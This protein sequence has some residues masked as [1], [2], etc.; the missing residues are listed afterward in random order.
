MELKEMIIKYEEL[1]A[2]KDELSDE[3]KANNAAIDEIKQQIADQM[4][5]D[6]MPTIGVGDYTYSLQMGIKYG[7]KSEAALAQ[8]GLNKMDVLR[9]NGY[10]FLITERV[11]PRT[12]N[13]TMREAAESEEGIPE[14]IEEI[15]SQY[16]YQDIG[17]RKSS[18]KALKKK[19]GE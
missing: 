10:G 13:S 8:A 3:T 16:E 5:E 1:R 17:R 9:E 18:N 11:D 4:I 7:F 19:R 12:L 15:L 6:D 14:K 2:R